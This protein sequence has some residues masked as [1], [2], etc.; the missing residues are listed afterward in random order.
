MEFEIF[1]DLNIIELFKF[2]KFNWMIKNQRLTEQQKI[3]F[4]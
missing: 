2:M 1:I 4:L 3:I